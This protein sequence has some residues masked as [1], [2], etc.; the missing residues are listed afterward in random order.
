[1]RRHDLTDLQKFSDF[2]NIELKISL[3]HT[4]L[5]SEKEVEGSAEDEVVLGMRYLSVLKF[6]FWIS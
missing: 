6:Y 2:Q 4:I 1:M 3:K 5:Y